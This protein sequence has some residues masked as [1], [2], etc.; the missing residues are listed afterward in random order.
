MY[1]K[2]HNFP[3]PQPWPQISERASKRAFSKSSSQQISKTFKNNTVLRNVNWDVKKGERVG[4]VG[5]NGAGKTT[6]LQVWQSVVGLWW[7][8][9][10]MIAFTLCVRTQTHT[11][12]YPFLS[13]TSAMGLADNHGPGPR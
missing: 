10:G 11:C 4:L 12:V 2:I 13:I 9:W 3:R 6:Q 5:I 8:L 7:H 1:G